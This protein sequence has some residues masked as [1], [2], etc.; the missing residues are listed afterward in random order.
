MTKSKYQMADGNL[1]IETGRIP[2]F[3]IGLWHWD[4]NVWKEK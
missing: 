3:D 4:L 2:S 1:L